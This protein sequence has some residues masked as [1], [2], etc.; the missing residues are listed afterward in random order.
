MRAKLKRPHMKPGRPARLYI[1]TIFGILVGFALVS[2]GMLIF[3]DFEWARFTIFLFFA[4]NFV[5]FPLWNLTIDRMSRS[6]PSVIGR[7]IAHKST[8]GIS[9]GSMS[10][11]TTD[12]TAKYEYTVRRKLYRH[13]FNDDQGKTATIYYH[14]RYPNFATLRQE[15]FVHL[16]VCL[17]AGL[18]LS[19]LAWGFY[20]EK[21]FPYRLGAMVSGEQSPGK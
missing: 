13:R 21:P 10:G 8:T 5:G 4:L 18:V 15:V 3:G 11:T 12:S 9:A 2:W 16:W 7:R 17:A 20:P 19:A 6:W 14:P 1:L